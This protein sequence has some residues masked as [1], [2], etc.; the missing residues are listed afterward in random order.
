M[1]QY[2]KKESMTIVGD[3]LQRR[4]FTHV[5]D[6]VEA[7]MLAAFT[8]N[9]EAFGEVFNVGYGKNYSILEL[10]QMIGGEYCHIDARPGEARH[11]LADAT[12]IRTSLNWNPAVEF[13]DWV[14]ENK[15]I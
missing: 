13:A 2:R 5:S 4:D 9:E 1:E 15:D 12:K 3:G 8:D 14:M 7:N 6:V 11:T 10:A